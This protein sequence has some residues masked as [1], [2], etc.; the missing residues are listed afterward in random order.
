[1]GQVSRQIDQ[2]IVEAGDPPKGSTVE[3]R[4]QIPTMQEMLRG[5]GVGLILAIVVIFLLLAANFNR[6]NSP[7][8]PFRLLPRLWPGSC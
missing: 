5:L 8:C 7:S 1:M 3:V 6:G 4:G 2:A